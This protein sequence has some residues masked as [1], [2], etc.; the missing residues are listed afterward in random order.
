MTEWLS[1]LTPIFH[2]S[3]V[4]LL[5]YLAEKTGYIPKIH[6]LISKIILN[7]TLPLLIIISISSQDFHNLPLLDLLLIF[8]IGI[9][10]IILLFITNWMISKLF[11]FPLQKQLLHAFLGS[12]GNVIFLAYPFILSLFGQQ[13]LFYAILF[14]LAND[15][16]LW[17]CGIWVFNLSTQPKFQIRFV[18]LVNLKWN[19]RNIINP[20]TISFIVGMLMLGLG[21]RFPSIIYTPLEKLGATTTPLSM[22]FIGSVLANVNLQQ[23]LKKKSIWTICFVKMILFP[24]LLIL[25]FR[26][27]RSLIYPLNAI[28]ISVIILQ[29]SMPT[30]ILLSVLA[31]KY[32]GDTEYAAQTIFITTMAS[33][34]ILPIMYY[35]C[36]AI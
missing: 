10:V 20:N 27:I 12:F 33:V 9:T 6:S 11:H 8:F 16:L 19:S 7:L 32:K 3:L 17:T 13:G 30:Q 25:F 21:F 31:D 4:V 15:L 26:I 2:L 28:L 34:F 36:I 18:D 5:G 24:V 23:S 35:L 1:A 14:S 29:V 22:L